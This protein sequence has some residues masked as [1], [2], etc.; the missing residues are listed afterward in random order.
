MAPTNETLTPTQTRVPNTMPVSQHPALSVAAKAFA[1]IG[2]G[3]GL[4]AL[5]RPAHALSF[6]EW[7]MPTS[8][9]ERQLVEALLYVYGVRDIFWGLSFYIANAFGTRK[10]TGWTFVAGSLVAF[11]DGAICYTWGKGQWGHW[12]YAPM[13]SALGAAFLGLFD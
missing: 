5:L 8:P 12:S 13:M 10:S 2:I 3:F 6:F 1:L 7:E 11:A 4:N 9:A